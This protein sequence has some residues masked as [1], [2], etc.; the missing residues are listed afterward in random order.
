MPVAAK[1]AQRLSAD[2]EAAAAYLA[3]TEKQL[4]A[5]QSRIAR[6]EKDRADQVQA[7]EAAAAQSRKELEMLRADLA[8]KEQALAEAG[9]RADQLQA[10]AK[11]TAGRL[12]ELD[13]QRADEKTAADAKPE[14]K[15]KR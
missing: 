10:E 12:A 13:K 8:A 1:Q 15:A 4:G 14:K 6:L 7:A 9:K 2:A 11:Q 5:E 3:A